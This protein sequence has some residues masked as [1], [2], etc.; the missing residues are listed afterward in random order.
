[1]Y[2]QRGVCGREGIFFQPLSWVIKSSAFIRGAGYVLAVMNGESIS[3][4]ALS[5]GHTLS[6]FR[7]MH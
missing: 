2:N 5:L 4:P 7:K 3:L 6:L 1:M